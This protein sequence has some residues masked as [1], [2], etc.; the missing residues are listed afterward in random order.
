MASVALLAFDA[1]D[2]GVVRTLAAA[3]K[4]P[5]FRKLFDEWASAKIL[6]PYGIFVGAIWPT[7]FTALSP[8]RVRFHCWET[9]S[10]A[11]YERRLTKASEIVGQPFWRRLGA[12]GRR[13]AIIDVPHIRVKGPVNGLEISEYGC[14]DRHFGFHASS[15]QLADEAVDRVGF[16]PVLSVDPFAERQFAPDDYLHREARLRTIEEERALLHDMLDGL[17]RKNRLSQWIFERERWDLFISV[18]GES[19]AIG[20]QSWH[21]HDPSHPRYDG[22][23]AKSIGDPLERVY[24]SLDRALAEHLSLLGKQGNVL[25]LLSHGMGPHYDGTQLLEAVLLRIEALHQSAM[26]GSPLV[27]VAKAA[28]ARLPESARMALSPA[29]AAMLRRRARRNPPA[30]SEEV[31]SGAANRAARRFFMTPNNS[32]YGGI[33][34]NLAGREPSGRVRPGR[35]LDAACEFIRRELLGLI[36]V[37]TGE[38]AVRSVERT[39]AYYDRAPDDELPDLFVDWNRNGPIE[40]VWSPRIGFVHAPYLHWRTGDHRLN[41]FLFASG[42]DIRP[43][44]N[45]GQIANGDLG[46]TIC[47]M[48][49]HRLDGVDG[50]P[51]PALLRTR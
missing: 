24:A 35:D 3:G 33:R 29:A 8:E 45:L 30:I 13:V 51:V 19:H 42:P 39:E 41:G 23:A 37:D 15:P 40:T 16:H 36:N 26:G 48:L 12:A 31:D 38:A 2:A 20:H 17:E 21:L 25:V 1:C 46:P 50:R 27:R 43:R 32:V 49:G 10:P 34:I 5:T 22:A 4:L 14:H 11:T 7:F 6:N 44:T 9:I 28:W 47:A 18:F